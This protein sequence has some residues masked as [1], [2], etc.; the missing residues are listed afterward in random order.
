M[1]R[2]DID[3]TGGLLRIGIIKCLLPDLDGAVKGGRGNDGT[4]LW[5]C[6]TE[7]GDCCVVRLR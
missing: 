4:K 2:C 1:R 6:P 5:M 7:L 3:G